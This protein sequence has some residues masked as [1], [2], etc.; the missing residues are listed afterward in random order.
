MPTKTKA[1]NK[2]KSTRPT[3]QETP[4]AR[5]A[6]EVAPVLAL[7]TS[8]LPTHTAYLRPAVIR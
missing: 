8:Y 5:V 6:D 1:R 2:A 4:L 3:P 7:P